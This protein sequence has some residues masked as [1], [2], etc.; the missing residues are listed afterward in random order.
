MNKTFMGFGF[1][2]VQSGLFLYESYLSGNFKRFVVSEI[3][4][5]LVDAIARNDGRYSLNIARADR[6]DP[7]SL[8]G[9]ELYDP[10]DPSGLDAILGAVAESDEMATALPSVNVYDAGGKGSVVNLLAE[11]MHRRKGPKPTVLYAAENNNR[12]AEIL[13]GK[14][15]NLPGRPGHGSFQILNTVVG[16]MSGV[17]TDPGVIGKLGLVPITPGMPRAILI[18]E[19]NR[20]LI[21]RAT[22][23]NY[24]RGIEVFVEKDDLLPFEEAKLYGHNA[25][26]S[27]IAYL[28]DLKGLNT[29]ADAGLNA[30]IIETARRAF[31]D[32]SGPAM[33]FRN[34]AT[35][36][37]LFT[38]D[39][40]RAYAE[41]LLERMV[42]PNLNDLV[43]RVGRDHIRKLEYND[44]LVG[45]MRLVLEAGLEPVNLARGAAACVLSMIKRRDE[46]K[47]SMDEVPAGPEDLTPERMRRLLL[48]LWGRE[49]GTDADRLIALIQQGLSSI[50][51]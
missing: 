18:E 21:S 6:I 24:E 34:A 2:P 12:A 48:K 23:P 50:R 41:D 25:I 13:D 17:I 45:T 47:E 49:A 43:S 1:G 42:C 38:P 20:I 32:E 29:M 5:R 27:L 35:G 22:L 39:G 4:K 46:L 19:F 8:E 10:G 51:N 37:P 3:D 28:A 44:R 11:G 14:L 33:I 16:K 36:D 40:Y 9:I 30:E 26:H 31:I 15:D 7:I